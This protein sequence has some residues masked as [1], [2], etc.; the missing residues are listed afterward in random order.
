[1]FLGY[2]VL[3][4]GMDYTLVLSISIMFLGYYVLV[5]CMDYTHENRNVQAYGGLSSC[6][7]THANPVADLPNLNYYVLRLLCSFKR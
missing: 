5:R 6:I 2:Y 1:M 4:R 7:Y 3:V